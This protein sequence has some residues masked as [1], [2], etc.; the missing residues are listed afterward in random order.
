MRAGWSEM[1]CTPSHVCDYRVALRI[2]HVPWL[3]LVQTLRLCIV[4]F[5]RTLAYLQTAQAM[6]LNATNVSSGLRP[7]EVRLPAGCIQETDANF[8]GD[9]VSGVLNNTMEGD[10]CCQLCR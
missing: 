7:F 9:L 5:C 1:S 6:L 10:Q 3:T 4:A 2:C 8:E